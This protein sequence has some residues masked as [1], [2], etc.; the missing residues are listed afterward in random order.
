[1]SASHISITLRANDEVAQFIAA[2]AQCADVTLD[3]AASV[4]V[5]LALPKYLAQD[6]VAIVVPD[7][8]GGDRASYSEKGSESTLPSSAGAPTSPR[9]EVR[10]DGTV[11]DHATGLMWTV[12]DV[13]ENRLNWN[14][15]DAA[16]KAVT[17]GGF[18]DWRLPT[19]Q[20][21]LTLVDDTRVNPAINKS[22]FPHCKS[23][24]YWTSTTWAGSPAAAAWFVHFY[25]GLSSANARGGNAR[26]RA[27]RVVS[28][29]GQ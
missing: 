6:A 17:L 16:A 1:M 3:Q 7:G 20:E 13:G 25:N 5:A 21:L 9:Y 26:V 27:V 4:I 24:W 11:T 28:S 22:V 18:S 14:D 19:R 8:V 15:A 23:A 12:D 2:A 29:A 10:S